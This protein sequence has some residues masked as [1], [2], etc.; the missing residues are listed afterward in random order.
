MRVILFSYSL[1]FICCF[2]AAPGLDFASHVSLLFQSVFLWNR[3][4]DWLGWIMF[5]NKSLQQIKP[6][7][8]DPG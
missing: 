7:I 3:M 2:T 6:A 1:S 8:V 5:I 4:Y